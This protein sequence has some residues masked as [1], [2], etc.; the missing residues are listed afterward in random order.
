MT[1]LLHCCQDVTVGASAENSA[2]L[3]GLSELLSGASQPSRIFI[4]S[5]PVMVSRSYRY[6]AS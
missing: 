5:S 3:W 4:N 1:C 6:W 2:G